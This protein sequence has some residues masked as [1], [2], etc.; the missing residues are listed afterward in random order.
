MEIKWSYVYKPPYLLTKY[1]SSKLATN[2][3]QTF[4]KDLLLIQFGL[5]SEQ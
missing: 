5:R 2:Q 1:H 4:L 3:G